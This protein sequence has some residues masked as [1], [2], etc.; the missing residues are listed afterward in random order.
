[1]L[2][3]NYDDV[4]PYIKVFLS[5]SNKDSWNLYFLAQY[6]RRVIVRPAA[7]HVMKLCISLKHNIHFVNKMPMS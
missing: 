2:H 6:L 3:C 4:K 7:S 5:I 1:M